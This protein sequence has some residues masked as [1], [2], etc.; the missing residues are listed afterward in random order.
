VA[1]TKTLSWLLF[2]LLLAGGVSSAYAE[3]NV[4]VELKGQ[5]GAPVDG[6]VELVKG[7]TRKAC[8][9]VKGRCEIHG[10]EGGMYNVEVK[11]PGK[12]SPKP[13]QVMIPPSGEAKLSVSAD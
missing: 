10:V 2:S 7:D 1:G 12:P 5:G 9:T 3:A 4:I 8:T 11:V 13:K 6:T